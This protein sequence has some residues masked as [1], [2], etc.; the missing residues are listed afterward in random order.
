MLEVAGYPEKNG[1]LSYVGKKT[2]VPLSTLRDW[3]AQKDNA[4]F[5]EVRNNKKTQLTERIEDLIDKTLIHAAGVMSGSEFKDAVT[6]AAILIDKLLLLK[7]EPT[8][9]TNQ[10]VVI[11]Y[12]E[13]I[14][15]EATRVA[16]E[17]YP[18]GEAL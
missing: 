6:S 1:S 17:C 15:A 7:G 16:D 5:T 2:G 10:H 8:E 3:Y 14:V 4:A 13:D 12:V 18:A 9:N 11:E